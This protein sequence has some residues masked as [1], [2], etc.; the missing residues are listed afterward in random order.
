[1]DANVVTHV[2]KKLNDSADSLEE[3]AQRIRS[4]NR[5]YENVG[6]PAL[7]AFVGEQVAKAFRQLAE[8]L[9]EP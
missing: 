8:D 9:S 1:M 4:E 7:Q 2:A 6:T 3:E 5:A